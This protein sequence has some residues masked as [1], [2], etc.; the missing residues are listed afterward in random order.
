MQKWIQLAE[1]LLEHLDYT[2]LS[3]N[4]SNLQIQQY[5]AGF[6]ANISGKYAR[7]REKA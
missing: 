5:L 1:K 3:F 4:R 6:R 7:K 2:D